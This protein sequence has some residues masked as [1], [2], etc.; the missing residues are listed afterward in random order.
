MAP[1]AVTEPTP[2]VPAVTKNGTT[3][4]MNGTTATHSS[5]SCFGPN[6]SAVLHGAKDLRIEERPYT[7]PS[8]DEVQI[9]VRA[10]G[11]CG[12]DLHYYLHG[13]NGDFAL[14]HSMCLGHESAGEIVALGP[15]VPSS[16]NLS[17]GDRV[18]IEAGRFCGSCPKCR[19]GRYNLCKQMR[20][21]SS[22]K[23]H[24]HL[25]GTLQKY[26]NWPSWLVH[27]LPPNVSLTSAALC[28]PLS[29]VLQGI[30][31]SQ[32][33]PG[34]SVLVYGAG[35]VGLLTCAAAKASGASFV[36]AVDIDE[37]RLAFASANG[38]ADA[39]YLLPRSAPAATA[40]GV[41]EQDARA[42]RVA[43]DKAAISSAST[44][45]QNL[46]QALS[47]SS[48]T[49]ARPTEYATQPAPL[50]LASDG[51]D[52]VFE[53]TGVPTC[54]QTGIFAS[55]AGG[56]MVLIGMGNPIQTLPIG[57]A[58]LREVDIVGVFRYA[59]TYPIALGLLAG[60]TLRAQGGGLHAQAST[61]EVEAEGQGAG[62]KMGGI[63]NLVS[64]TYPLKQAVK[65][66][67]TLANGKDAEHGRGVVKV[68]ITDNEA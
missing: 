21:A 51:F 38:W 17:V 59:N 55:K 27:K 19:D 22:A 13:R 48:S 2:V 33:Q 37:G 64:H 46:L 3:E 44:S 16:A 41:Q 63:E 53:C 57:S 12:S 49:A 35:A 36:A 28:E 4:A 34:Q 43:E 32:L 39:T 5:S 24:P 60:G 66:F 7:T 30:R 40:N 62:R 31:R 26:M 65:A 42:R 54:V 10:T 29:V 50:D 47:T 14:Q 58:S 68:F 25:D 56:K 23:T 61:S 6:T 18:A 11:L 20:F 9:R 67:E 8:G 45:A 1:I 52:V 15:N